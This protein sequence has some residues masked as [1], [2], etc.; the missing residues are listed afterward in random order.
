MSDPEKSPNVQSLRNRDYYRAR[1]VGAVKKQRKEVHEIATPSGESLP[2]EFRA[3][4]LA[5]KQEIH[6]KASNLVPDAA[7]PNGFRF[8]FNQLEFA[9][10]AAIECT[11]IPGTEERVY[12]EADL[13]RLRTAYATNDW[14]EIVMEEA[15][16]MLK[17]KPA[18]ETAKNSVPTGTASSSSK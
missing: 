14:E 7:A 17:P 18:E 16:A 4:T 1:T 13:E 15:L 8:D 5:K 9:A 12:E 3:P 2:F 10:R 11:F 6:D